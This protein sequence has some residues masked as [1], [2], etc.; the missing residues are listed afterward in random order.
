MLWYSNQNNGTIA[1]CRMVIKCD[2]KKNVENSRWKKNTSTG[3]TLTPLM[4][5]ELVNR[6]VLWQNILHT[7]VYEQCEQT[8]FNATLN[9]QNP[10]RDYNS[11]SRRTRLTEM[12]N[13]KLI[14]IRQISLNLLSS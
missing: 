8:D 4:I 2:I 12:T 1:F 3:T 11:N 10:I 14:N 5:I 7:G 9:C 6:K 13:A